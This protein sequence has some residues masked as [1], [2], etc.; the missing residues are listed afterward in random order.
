MR[1]HI[2]LFKIEAVEHEKCLRE[3]DL[4]QA[5]DLKSVQQCSDI[6]NNGQVPFEELLDQSDLDDSF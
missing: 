4:N 2:K 1:D 3:L 6:E 5:L